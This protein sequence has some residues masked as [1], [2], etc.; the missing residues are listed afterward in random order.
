MA[1]YAKVRRMFFREK[2][3][4]SEIQR[5]TSLS[6][7]TVRKWLKAEATGGPKYER[8]GMATKLKPFEEQL[9]RSLEADALRPKRD[10]RTALALF[11]ELQLAGFPGSHPRVCDFVRQR[12][13]SSKMSHF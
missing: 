11:A 10:R 3:S 13:L 7:N 2:L 9:R 5:R 8:R 4:I 6:R 1:M 12:S